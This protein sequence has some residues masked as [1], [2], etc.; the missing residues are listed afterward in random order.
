MELSISGETEGVVWERF[1]GSSMT[2]GP[3]LPGHPS[4]TARGGKHFTIMQSDFLVR[5]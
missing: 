2:A 4:I 3:W 1:T 5:V